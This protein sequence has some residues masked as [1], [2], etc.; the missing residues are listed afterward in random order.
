MT[1]FLFHLQST[2]KWDTGLSL[3]T[4][5]RNDRRWIQHR[6]GNWHGLTSSFPQRLLS[7]P[8]K[9]QNINSPSYRLNGKMSGP[10]HVLSIKEFSFNSPQFFSPTYWPLVFYRLKKTSTVNNCRL[11]FLG[12]SNISNKWIIEVWKIYW[13][14]DILFRW[15]REMNEKDCQIIEILFLRWSMSNKQM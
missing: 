11:I 3:R 5:S 6:D 13:L 1:I 14:S 8:G 2:R 12:P 10:C 15:I 4:R 9:V 7:D